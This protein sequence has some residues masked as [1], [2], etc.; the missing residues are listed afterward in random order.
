MACASSLPSFPKARGPDCFADALPF[1]FAD[2]F[3][4][5]AF[6]LAGASASGVF[7]KPFASSFAGASLSNSRLPGGK[8][9][10]NENPY[11]K[12]SW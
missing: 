2:F 9:P 11:Q 4:A 7:K 10:P 6:L 3:V 8:G 12:T 5:L 1:A